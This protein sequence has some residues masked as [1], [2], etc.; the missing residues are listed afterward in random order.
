MKFIRSPLM[1]VSTK[2]PTVIAGFGPPR[3]R[4]TL[5]AGG[6]GSGKTVLALQ[7][8][9]H[10]ARDCKAPGISGDGASPASDRGLK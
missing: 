3:G 7:F 10:D 8:P 6:L 9:A 1:D 4:T 2:A 5:L